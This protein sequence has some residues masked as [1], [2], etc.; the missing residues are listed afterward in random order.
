MTSLPTSSVTSSPSSTRTSEVTSS[1]TSSPSSTRTS[2]VTGSVTSSMTSLPTSSVTSSVTSLPTSSVT[3]S[4]SSTMTS[5]VTSSVSSLPTS[6]VTSSHSLTMTSEVTSFASSTRT[7][8]VTGSVTSS[9]SSTIS[10]EVTSLETATASATA[11]VSTSAS[12]TI[13]F[14]NKSDVTVEVGNIVPGSTVNSLSGTFA[15]I[16]TVQVSPGLLGISSDQEAAANIQNNPTGSITTS[17]WFIGVL[18]AG[19][20]LM[21]LL[22]AAGVVIMKHRKTSKKADKSKKDETINENPMIRVDGI[23]LTSITPT[24]YEGISINPILAKRM[25]SNV[26][27]SHITRAFGQNTNSAEIHRSPENSI[28]KAS[29]GKASVGKLSGRLEHAKE[30]NVKPEYLKALNSQGYTVTEKS[31]SRLHNPGNRLSVDRLNKKR[32]LESYDIK[33]TK[34]EFEA[35]PARPINKYKVEFPAQL[36]GTEGQRSRMPQLSLYNMFN[37]EIK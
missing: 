16:P 34:A 13:S 9:P 24:L 26:T 7:S 36:T 8:D 23:G 3:S 30:I 21:G 25:S 31:I 18:A 28:G 20:I 14:F 2:D 17:S 32:I 10:S 15:P 6:S 4:H 19:F 11:S 35:I 37:K 33:D 27:A 22:V 1:V 29:V 12:A 5:E